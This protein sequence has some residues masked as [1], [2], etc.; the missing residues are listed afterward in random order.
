MSILR[1]E[2][3]TKIGLLGLKDDREAILTTLHDLRVQQIEPISPETLVHLQ[4]ERASDI[5][6]T[7]SDEALRLRGLKSALP[8]VPVGTPRAF[9]D[10]HEV[11][12][13]AKTVP[14]DD[15]VGALVREEDRLQSQARGLSDTLTLL[16]K[17]A[18]YPDRL[19]YLSA[20]AHAAYLVE[21]GEDPVGT[22]RAAF[23]A[24]AQASV[25]PSSDGTAFLA[26]LPR[27]RPD[28]VGR[29]PPS[30]GVRLLPIPNLEGTV[31]E[32]AQR[33]RKE[34]A[35]LATR[36][37]EIADRLGA[38]SKEWYPLVAELDEALSIHGRL[39]EVYPKLGASANLFAVEGWIPRR[40]VERLRATID[41]VTT[42]R[43]FYYRVPTDELPPTLMNNPGVSKR[44]E[45][46]VRFYSLPQATEWDPTIV[47]AIVFP[48]FFGFMLG[49]WGYASA[50]LAICLWMIAG[51]PG[52]QHLPRMLR[53]FVTRIMGPEGM[54]K[55]AYALIP[56]CLVALALGLYFDLFFGFGIFNM[57]WGYTPGVQLPPAQHANVAFLLLLS[58][59]IGVAMVTLG[60]AMGAIKEFVHRHRRGAVAK[61]GGIIATWG[62]ALFGLNVIHEGGFAGP[63]L[64][65]YLGIFLAGVVILLY[66]EGG[67]GIM[68]LIEIVSHVL[69]YTRLVG[70]L[71]ASVILAYVIDHIGTRLPYHFPPELLIVGFIVGA[72]L[73]VI[74]QSFNL[75][76]GVFEP[77]I[78]GAR[79]IFVEYFSK[80]YSGNGKEFHPFGAARRHTLAPTSGGAVGTNSAAGPILRPSNP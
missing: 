20:H 45:F 36:R 13:V 75:I 16:G 55:L 63:L 78:Q 65:P 10:L 3:M 54:R 28:L 72:L 41:R 4:P 73:I 18:F 21:G 14:I 19:T 9:R 62:V 79:L 71:L 7:V 47:F 68:G 32:E 64:L 5:Q 39:F 51:F 74:G 8:R 43:S 59:Y 61:I 56:G 40:D 60:F 77:G 27:D 2:P 57:L 50:I 70:I 11:L 37:Q 26:I 52:G 22:L 33:T 80:F 29:I 24:D 30:S 25:L 48:I 38:I 42:G 17:L 23:P 66:G 67:A 49:D 1:P 53:N 69:S 35:T 58:G 34:L 6:R 31:A 76:L 44:Y 12:E 46:F 15:E